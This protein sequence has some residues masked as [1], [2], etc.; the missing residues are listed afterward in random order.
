MTRRY[1]ERWQVS[2][3]RPLVKGIDS[4][5]FRAVDTRGEYEGEYAL[6]HVLHPLRQERFH[7]ELDSVLALRHPNVMALVDASAFT[8]AGGSPDNQFLV[9]PFAEGGDLGHGRRAEFYKESLDYTLQLARQMAS[10]LQAAHD[11]GVI[12]RDLKPNN[13]LFMGLGHEVWLSDFG[14]CLIREPARLDDPEYAGQGEFL[15]PEL[16][17][18]RQLDV[19]PAADVY[20]LGKVL[21]YL[22]SGGVTVV[23]NSIE[24]SKYSAM[25]QQDKRRKLL[26]ALLRQM[27][28]PLENRLKTIPEVVDQLLAIQNCQ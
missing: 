23:G 8:H 21:Y 18:G 16:E 24:P 9:M 4:E 28:C 11:S 3:D 2:S 12:H 6:K 13:V 22:Y 14:I 10:A 27:I 7:R 1:G 26:S 17:G 15:A 25:L 20:S 19:P 5:I